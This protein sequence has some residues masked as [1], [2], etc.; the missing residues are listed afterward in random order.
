MVRVLIKAGGLLTQYLKP[1]AG[2]YARTVEARDGETLRQI[3][4]AIGVPPGHVAVATANGRK[5]SLDEA[6]KDGDEIAL[7]PPVQGG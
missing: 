6:P 1:E 4:E 2:T 3:L 5:V 7:L